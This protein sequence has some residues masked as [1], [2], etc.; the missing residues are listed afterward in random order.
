MIEAIPNYLVLPNGVGTGGQP[1]EA[2]LRE[3]AEAE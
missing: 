1:S 2:Q 3:L